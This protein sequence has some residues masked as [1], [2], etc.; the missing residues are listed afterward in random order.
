MGSRGK[1]NLEM[2]GLSTK[3]LT[4][5][6]CLKPETEPKIT[7][8]AV[9]DLPSASF[10]AIYP[11]GDNHQQLSETPPDDEDIPLI[12]FQNKATE[13]SNAVLEDYT[14]KGEKRKRRKFEEPVSVR[15]AK[16]IKHNKLK[17]SLKVPCINTCKKKCTNSFTDDE[18]QNINTQYWQMTFSE[19]RNFVSSYVTSSEVKRH[20]AGESRRNK[21]LRYFFKCRSGDRVE[22][23]KLFFLSTLGYNKNNDRIVQDCFTG[24]TQKIIS[25]TSSKQGKHTKTPKIDRDVIKAHVETFNPAVSHYRREHAP[26]KRYL[27]SDLNIQLLY[28]DFKE[29]NTNFACSYEVYRN[30]VT[31]EMKISFTKLG[32]EECEIC[33]TFS[34][35]NPDHTKENPCVDCEKCLCWKSH[36]TKAN[37]ARSAY[38][39]DKELSLENNN[40]IYFSA[41]LQ[42]V[43]MLPRLDMFKKVIFCPRIIVFNQSFVPIGKKQN[44][45]PVALLWHEG[46]TGRQ[47]GDLVTMYYNFFLEMR[48]YE[49]IVLW[50]DNCSSQNKNWTLFSFLIYIVNSLETSI[51]E[52]VFKYFEPGHTFMSADHFHHQV[53]VS[54]K[55][56]PK[57]YDFKDFVDVVQRANSNKVKVITPQDFYEWE[58]LSSAYKLKRQKPRVYLKDIVQIKATRGKRYLSYKKCFT[59]AEEFE[60]NFLKNEIFKNGI[61]SP[62]KKKSLRGITEHRK[63]NILKTLSALMPENR[64]EFWRNLHINNEASDLLK[65]IED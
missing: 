37:E 52:I 53:E 50:V 57:I 32:H 12:F 27:P 1:K 42:K 62:R 19:K 64:L 26:H 17:H 28:S 55:K 9:L 65:D 48:D 21:T 60:L 36:I 11:S 30:V 58:D 33:E 15:K 54:M 61:Q 18:R 31:K 41:D 23:C 45:L 7:P 47:K 46:L 25:H 4:N 59:E 16:K 2:L 13:E 3:F 34:L 8:K 20:R 49:N 6:E 22:V 39:L 43:I 38:K 51:K 29:K 10:N 56:T 44:K 40:T 5:V 14:K 63:N 35:H 24:D